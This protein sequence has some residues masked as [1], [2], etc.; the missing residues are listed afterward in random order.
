MDWVESVPETTIVDVPGVATPPPSVT[1]TR[2]PVSANVVPPS[3]ETNRWLPCGELQRPIS[4]EATT[5]VE[6]DAAIAAGPVTSAQAGFQVRH[7]PP[8]SRAPPTT[9]RSFSSSQPVSPERTSWIAGTGPPPTAT[10]S[11][12]K[13]QASLPTGLVAMRK[14]CAP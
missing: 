12:D 8:T 10:W 5:S 14:C 13:L 4:H 3:P 9:V 2:L 6:L 7:V 1:G 11:G